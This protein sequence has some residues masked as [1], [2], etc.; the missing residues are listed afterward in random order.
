[1]K[2]ERTLVLGVAGLTFV[3]AAGA[4]LGIPPQGLILALVMIVCTAA[5]VQS[6]WARREFRDH[7]EPHVM[8]RR[9]HLHGQDT[10]SGPLIP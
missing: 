9:K 1:M 10:L 7:L 2:I 4:I 5:I 3:A 6:Y 8:V